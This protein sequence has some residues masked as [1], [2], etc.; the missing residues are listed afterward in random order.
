[1]S[2]RKQVSDSF[3]TLLYDTG[4]ESEFSAQEEPFLRVAEPKPEK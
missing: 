4:E 2:D 3:S 1:M